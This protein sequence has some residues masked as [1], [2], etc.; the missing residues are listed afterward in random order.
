MA[1]V[2]LTREHQRRTRQAQ[3]H[4]CPG[5]GQLHAPP[6][7]RS[8]L[9]WTPPAP[10]EQVLGLPLHRYLTAAQNCTK[11]VCT[12]CLVFLIMYTIT[13][14]TN[15]RDEYIKPI[16]NGFFNFLLKTNI[17]SEL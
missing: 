13:G 5:L 4:E 7:R 1:R 12:A 2:L 6:G 3:L 11:L 15:K 17:D 16:F 8:A 10:A 9:P 14:I